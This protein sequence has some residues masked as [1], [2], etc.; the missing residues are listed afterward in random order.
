MRSPNDLWEAIGL[1]GEDEVPH[2]LT[3]LF[4]MYDAMLERNP[5]DRNAQLF[6][7]NLDS[8][9]TQSTTCNLNR[10]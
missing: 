4:F 9:I 2:V 6:F 3:K 5:G 10:R 1:L 8:A 7:R